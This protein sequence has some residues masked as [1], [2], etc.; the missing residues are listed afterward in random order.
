MSV[1]DV[2]NGSLQG[3]E[4]SLGKRLERET[5]YIDDIKRGLS[6]IIQELKSC[7]QRTAVGITTGNLTQSELDAINQRILTIINQLRDGAPFGSR[8]NQVQ[9]TLK[10]FQN[11]AIDHLY[12]NDAVKK[13]LTNAQLFN[14]TPQKQTGWFPFRG[15]KSKRFRTK[16]LNRTR[17][18]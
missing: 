14:Y 16:Q 1:S 5:R 2:L 6:K 11:Y 4:T 12:N 8:N 9:S 3:L 13:N 17:Q 7:I 10:P 15:G 18:H